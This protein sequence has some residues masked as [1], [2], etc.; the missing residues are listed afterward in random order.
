MN[1]LQPLSTFPLLQLPLP[2]IFQLLIQAWQDYR[3]KYQC[4]DLAVH[5]DMRSDHGN[6]NIIA[7]TGTAAPAAAFA[8]CWL[9]EHAQ[10]MHGG[11]FQDDIIA[12]VV[13]AFVLKHCAAAQ[14]KKK[15]R[16]Q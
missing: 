11:S 3:C 5:F 8:S 9:Q 6:E 1:V 13:V 4:D 14:P 7:F 15:T 2:A 10:T 16:A 12:I